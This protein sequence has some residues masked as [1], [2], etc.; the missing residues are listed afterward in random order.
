MFAALLGED[1]LGW[2]V[3]IGSHINTVSNYRASEEKEHT[4]HRPS[5]PFCAP[6]GMQVE[7][8]R[9]AVVAKPYSS[10]APNKVARARFDKA[11]FSS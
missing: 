5:R 9:S 7:A 8:C 10:E 4:C 11:L 1:G 2:V 3:A 6:V